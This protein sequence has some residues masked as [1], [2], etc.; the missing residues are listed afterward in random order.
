[1][2]D[3]IGEQVYVVDDEP[4]VRTV[5]RKT[6]ERVGLSVSCFDSA[7]GCL[8]C[9]G[10]GTCDLLITDVRMPGKDGIE[11]LTEVRRL[12]PWLPVIVVTGFGD[13]P[14]AVKALKAGAADFVEKPLDRDT[15]LEAVQRLLAHNA[16]PRAVLHRSLTRME[17]KVL[18]G[19]L[20]GKNNREVAD[21]LHR[22]ARTVEV[23]R[24]HL[25]RKLRASNVVELLREAA[26]LR[27]F[28]LDASSAGA[29]GATDVQE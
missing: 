10:S 27:L 1:M 13:V 25:M 9:L 28:D 20:E 23:H 4:K 22:S 7:D 15:F 29:S 5:V 17:L 21:V 8:A 19:I 3:H 6:L 11:L 16:I 18:Y 14:M 24:R 12:Q 26:R 2:D